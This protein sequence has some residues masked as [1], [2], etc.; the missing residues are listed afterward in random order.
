MFDLYKQSWFGKLKCPKCYLQMP[1]LNEIPLLNYWIVHLSF[2]RTQ[3]YSGREKNFCFLWTMM[4]DL[5]LTFSH[6]SSAFYSEMDVQLQYFLPE[7]TL[8]LSTFMMSHKMQK[9]YQ[10]MLT[11]H[12]LTLNKQILKLSNYWMVNTGQLQGRN[13]KC[14]Y[15]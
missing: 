1:W 13:L 2:L 6:V 5:K 10:L 15:T 11:N 7:V 12:L 9:T 3:L 4:L 8:H 14:C